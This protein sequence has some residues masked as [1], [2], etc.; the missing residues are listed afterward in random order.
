MQRS[1]MASLGV[2]ALT[3]GAGCGATI[4]GF[5]DGGTSL[6]DTGA[7]DV[8]TIPDDGGIGFGDATPIDAGPPD[9]KPTAVNLIPNGDFSLGNTLF[10]S[11]YAYA[12]I[13]ATEGQYTVGTDPN[14]FNTSLVS[15]GDHTTGKGLM[16]IGNGKSSPDR[17][18]YT[19]NI[20]VSPNTTYYFEAWILNGCCRPGTGYGDGVHP[21][22]PSI[23]SFYINGELLG[24]RTSSLLGQ[25]EGMSTTWNSGSTT[26]VT[27]QLVNAN[28]VADGNDFAVDD[29]Y[30]GTVSTVLPN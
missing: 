11:D 5:D 12:V 6:P 27:L 1:W 10:G 18:W 2:V 25:W 17:V 21:V 22:G 7:G 3:C 4:P 30:L 8:A 9:A 14:A 19:S 29:V 26:T 28:T 15:V 13:N 23:L 20:T 24:T 16:F